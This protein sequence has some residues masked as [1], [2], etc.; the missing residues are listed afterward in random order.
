MIY[1]RAR[2][3]RFRRD[4]RPSYLLKMLA[5][6][7]KLDICVT[8]DDNLRPWRIIEVS[9][10]PVSIGVAGTLLQISRTSFD[11]LLDPQSRGNDTHVVSWVERTTPLTQ[12]LGE[13]NV[14]LHEN[15]S[16]YP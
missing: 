9:V 8:I 15:A 10:Q 5:D 4:I 2:N 12:K 3:M 1:L 7:R 13:R 16:R 6:V 14:V 11:A